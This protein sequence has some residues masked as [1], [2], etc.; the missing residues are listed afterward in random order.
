MGA[1]AMVED[2][3]K[4]K[5]CGPVMVRLAFHDSGTYDDSVT[6]EWPAAGGAVGSI[7]FE[8]EI[9][10]GAN[11]GLAG[12]VKLLEPVKE[13]FPAVSYADLFQMASARGIALAGG[14]VIDMKYGRVDVT[15]GDQCSP[16]GNLPDA[17][18]GDNGKFGGAGGTKSTEDTTPGGHLRKVFHRMGLND[19]D[20]VALSGAHT[21]GTSMLMSFDLI[22]NGI[23]LT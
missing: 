18:A 6:G 9:N 14:P 20:I 2:I 15:S 8:P 5:N 11:A 1:Q 3:L 17:E 19:E 7:R 23:D 12:A 4:E 13:K 22:W 21:F 10:H 16:E